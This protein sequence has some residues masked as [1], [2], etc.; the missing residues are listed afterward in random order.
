MKASDQLRDLV[1]H[2]LPRKMC[3]RY[4]LNCV[5]PEPIWTLYRRQ[6]SLIAI[7]N[8]TA[9]FVGRT[10]RTVTEPSE[11]KCSTLLKFA[12]FY[13]YRDAD[14]QIENKRRKAKRN[15]GGDGEEDPYT[16]AFLDYLAK[17][18]SYIYRWN[19]TAPNNKDV[20]L[21]AKKAAMRILEMDER[22]TEV[23]EFWHGHQVGT[24]CLT[25]LRKN[26]KH[27]QHT[28]YSSKLFSFKIHYN[29]V[30]LEHSDHLKLYNYFRKNIYIGKLD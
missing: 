5:G 20:E 1:A 28:T 17:A 27:E 30:A 9:I 21:D 10:A 22:L 15:K 16:S 13:R 4:S 3:H 26:M 8:P 23:T 14:K 7:K 2:P 24:L 12:Y 29:T 6:R 11:L 19:T 25:E 18:I